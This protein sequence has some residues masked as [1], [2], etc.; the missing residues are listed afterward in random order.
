MRRLEYRLRDSAPGLL[1]PLKRAGAL[2]LLTAA[3]LFAQ[4]DLCALASLHAASGREQAASDYVQQRLDERVEVD[5][6]GSVS[7]TFGSGAPHTLLIAGLDEPGYIVSGIT[8]EGYL[9]LERLVDPAPHYQFDTFFQGWPVRVTTQDRTSVTGVM[10]APSVH[11]DSNASAGRGVENLFV[12]LGAAGRE[13]VRAAGVSVLDAMTLEKQCVTLGERAEATAPW[14][15]SRAGAAILLRLAGLLDREQPRGAF[16]PRTVW[17]DSQQ[18]AVISPGAR[19]SGTPA[20]I[21]D[22]AQLKRIARLLAGFLNVGW[23][24]PPSG[25]MEPADRAVQTP[26]REAFRRLRF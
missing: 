23:H 18:V 20:E 15:S 19:H 8:E 4:D 24:Q 2:L 12:D 14:I 22:R 13:E 5:N 21:V 6:T 1:F 11:F 16:G 25:R 9:R 7:I 26:V 10:A 17:R 3:S